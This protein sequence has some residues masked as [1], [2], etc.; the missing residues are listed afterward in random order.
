MKNDRV[1]RIFY[2]LKIQKHNIDPMIWSETTYNA[3]NVMRHKIKKKLA[4]KKENKDS[5]KI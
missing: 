5:K 2:E 1:L 3:K 4:E